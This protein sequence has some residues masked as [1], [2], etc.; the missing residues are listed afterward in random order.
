MSNIIFCPH[1][2]DAIFSL[3]DYIID[4]NNEY[5][6]A[7]AFAGIPTDDA[8]YKKHTILRKEHEDACSMLGLKVINGD[9][10]DDVYGKQDEELLVNW[11]NET[12][13]NY[14]SVYIPL[15]IHHPD[16]IFLSNAMFDLI[17]NFDKNYFIYAELPYTILYPELYDERLNKFKSKY[18]LNKVNTNFTKRKSDALKK[19]ESQIKNNL[20]EKLLVKENLW[21]IKND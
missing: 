15:G 12:I 4:N 8:G 21:V 20:I 11:I 2:D 17:D 10:L 3:G 7:S 13:E 16:H 9:I 1:T 18:K 5:T 14:S 19:Y 6:I